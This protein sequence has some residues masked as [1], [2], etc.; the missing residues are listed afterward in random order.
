MEIREILKRGTAEPGMQKQ[1]KALCMNLQFFGGDGP[2]DPTDP[3][4]P[5]PSDP[6]PPKT[7]TQ[8]QYDSTNM[9]G[10]SEGR[11][12]VLKLLGLEDMEALNALLPVLQNA[13]TT[14]AS[15]QS[16]SEKYDAANITIQNKNT[17]IATLQSENALLKQIAILQDNGILGEEAAI[18]APGL[19]AQVTEEKDFAAVVTEFL[20]KYPRDKTTAKSNMAGGEM[21]KG[22][23]APDVTPEEFHKMTLTEKTEIAVKHPALYETLLK[24]KP[25]AFANLTLK[26]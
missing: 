25:N 17:E 13:Q 11:N 8:K 4:D 12:E 6:P 18:L 19:A 22:K 3:T 20:E 7:Y 2:T 14:A 21:G 5:P 10:K 23:A 9:A 26:Q 16:F 1:G 15:Q 24:S